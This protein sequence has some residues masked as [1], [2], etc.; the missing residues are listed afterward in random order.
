MAGLDRKQIIFFIRHE[1]S[2]KLDHQ[3]INIIPSP[4]VQYLKQFYMLGL[5]SK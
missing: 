3:L 4:I 1:R 5:S 2:A